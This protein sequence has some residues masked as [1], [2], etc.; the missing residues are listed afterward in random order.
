MVGKLIF[1]SIVILEVGSVILQNLKTQE[2]KP[3]AFITCFYRF[4][5]RRLNA[6]LW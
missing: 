1:T 2:S 3:K 5:C 4:V 6:V